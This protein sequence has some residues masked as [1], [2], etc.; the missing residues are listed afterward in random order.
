MLCPH[1]G[2]FTREGRN[3]HAVFSRTYTAKVVHNLQAF[4]RG[5]RFLNRENITIREHIKQDLYENVC[6]QK[7]AT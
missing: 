4:Q 7:I 5:E 1:S 3:N 6:M 2:V